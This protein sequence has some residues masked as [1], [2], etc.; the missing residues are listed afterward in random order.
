ME[1]LLWKEGDRVT[2]RHNISPSQMSLVPGIVKRIDDRSV[3]IEVLFRLGNEWVKERRIVDPRS[4]IQR[5][6][7]VATLDGRAT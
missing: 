1:K 4:L 6:K 5:T 2:W 3:T 7:H